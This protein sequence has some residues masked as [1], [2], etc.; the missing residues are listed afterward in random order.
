MITEFWTP[1]GEWTASGDRRFVKATLARQYDRTN[2]KV[3]LNED[4]EIENVEIIRKE[5]Q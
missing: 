2:L 4:G 3:T 1:D 5:E